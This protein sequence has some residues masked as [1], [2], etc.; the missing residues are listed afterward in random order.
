MPRGLS[1]SKYRFYIYS[2]TCRTGSVEAFKLLKE[3]QRK[4]KQESCFMLLASYFYFLFLFRTQLNLLGGNK[5][6]RFSSQPS[7]TVRIW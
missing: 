4:L 1:N 2:S 6:L 3:A 5:K 7:T